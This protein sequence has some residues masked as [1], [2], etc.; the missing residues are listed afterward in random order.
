MK[1]PAGYNVS[2]PT[3]MAV[4]SSCDKGDIVHINDGAH[5]E[6]IFGAAALLGLGGA[7]ILVTSLSMVSH[8]IGQETVSGL[9]NIFILI[10]R[11]Y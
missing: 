5:V 4:I 2:N 10:D 6:A 8:M 7:T 11:I 3:P 1:P 9:C